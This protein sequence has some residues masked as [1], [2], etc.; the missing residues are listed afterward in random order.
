MSLAGSSAIPLEGMWL[1]RGGLVL[2]PS[3]TAPGH[4]HPPLLSKLD[5]KGRTGFV[6]DSTGAQV[7]LQGSMS[8]TRLN[9]LFFKEA[10]QGWAVGGLGPRAM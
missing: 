7:F 1:G 10:E 6:L 8:Y 9:C 2:H 5:K 4:L 3:V